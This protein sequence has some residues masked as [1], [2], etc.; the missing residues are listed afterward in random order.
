MSL[1]VMLRRSAIAVRWY[2]GGIAGRVAGGMNGLAEH[3]AQRHAL[4]SSPERREGER[5][6]V[7]GRM[8]FATAGGGRA[9][10]C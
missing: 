5:D 10:E 6:V 8:W 4:A 3:A 7:G 1:L 2:R 9:A